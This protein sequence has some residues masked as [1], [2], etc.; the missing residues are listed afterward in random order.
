MENASKALIIA[1]AI[2]VAILLISIGVIL[3]NQGRNITDV[4]K[5]QINTEEIESF[6]SQFKIYEGKKVVGSEVKDLI[7]KVNTSNTVRSAEDGDPFYI[8][9]SGTTDRGDVSSN[10]HYEVTCTI[11]SGTGLVSEITIT[12][13]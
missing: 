4:G 12:S 3:V 5:K 10:K 2:L 8:S 11:D 9:L 1:G 7:D 6:N 13:L